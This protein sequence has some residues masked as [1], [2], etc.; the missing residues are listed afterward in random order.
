MHAPKYVMYF[1]RELPGDMGMQDIPIFADS[2]EDVEDKLGKTLLTFRDNESLAARQKAGCRVAGVMRLRY[3]NSAHL[4]AA[5]QS[6]WRS[7]KQ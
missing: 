6:E 4:Q 7:A 5:Q 1:Y 2:I 3:P